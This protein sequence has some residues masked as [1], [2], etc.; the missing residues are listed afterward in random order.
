MCVLVL[1]N[2][3]G[4]PI[5]LNPNVAR[6]SL[7]IFQIKIVFDTVEKLAHLLYIY[8]SKRFRCSQVYDCHHRCISTCEVTLQARCTTETAFFVIVT[9]A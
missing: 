9:L 3:V 4:D 8:Y 5:F 2:F 1:D 7:I 6:M